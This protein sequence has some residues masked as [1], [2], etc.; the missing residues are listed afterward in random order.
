MG[1]AVEG[2]AVGDAV[3]GDA[4]GST[5]AI[6]GA[7]DVGVPVGTMPPFGDCVSALGEAVVGDLVD[8]TG[9]LG[10]KVGT[11]NVVGIGVV[12]HTAIWHCTELGT[13]GCPLCRQKAASTD[14][15][16]PCTILVHVAVDVA[17]PSP[18]VAVQDDCNCC[19]HHPN[20]ADS[21]RH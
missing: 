1:D 2:D 9:I 18:H 5:T 13:Q 21:A 17:V 12:G 20:T 7:C 8:G 11:W 15:S 19:T 6:V 3:E 14:N 4:V 16:T 10:D